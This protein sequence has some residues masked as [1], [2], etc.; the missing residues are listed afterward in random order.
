MKFRYAKHISLNLY[1][2][3]RILCIIMHE[4]NSYLIYVN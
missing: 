2:K 3:N 4:S 1:G